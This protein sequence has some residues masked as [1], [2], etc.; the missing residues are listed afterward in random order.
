[1]VPDKPFYHLIK[2]FFGDYFP[3]RVGEDCF[4]QLGSCEFPNPREFVAE[5]NRQLDKALRHSSFVG[6]LEQSTH[7]KRTF[8][9]LTNFYMNCIFFAFIIILKFSNKLF[10][11]LIIFK[12]SVGF[13]P[14]YSM[15]N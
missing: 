7:L 2:I 9:Q 8:L 3:I 5:K 15:V 10:K 14:T 13:K 12:V 6:R 11:F 1:V 4:K